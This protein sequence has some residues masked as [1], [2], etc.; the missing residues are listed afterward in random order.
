M[1]LLLLGRGR[2]PPAAGCMGLPHP[3]DLKQ[4]LP[5]LRSRLLLRLL[6]HWRC[7]LRVLLLHRYSRSRRGIALLLPILLL[8]G[9]LWS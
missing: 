5:L 3:A 6:R 7:L 9:M 1:L 2:R 4:A 8:L